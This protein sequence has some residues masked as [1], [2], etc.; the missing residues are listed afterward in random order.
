MVNKLEDLKIV[1]GWFWVKISTSD[2]SRKHSYV[3]QTWLRNLL[4]YLRNKIRWGERVWRKAVKFREQTK[5]NGT[6]EMCLLYEQK[7][8]GS[9]LRTP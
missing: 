5:G 8:L 9:V 1:F 3:P 6:L 7:A 4:Y 2:I